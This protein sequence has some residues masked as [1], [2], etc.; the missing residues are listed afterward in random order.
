MPMKEFIFSKF[1]GSQ[2]ATLREMNL[3]IAIF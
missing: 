1:P 2:T 3:F